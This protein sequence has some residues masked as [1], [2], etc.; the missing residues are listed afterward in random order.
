MAKRKLELPWSA[1]EHELESVQ[2]Q[3]ARLEREIARESKPPVPRRTVKPVSLVERT[4]LVS[5]PPKAEAAPAARPLHP[6]VDPSSTERPPVIVVPSPAQETWPSGADLADPKTFGVKPPVGDLA[7][8]TAAPEE[9]RRR[10]MQHLG[11]A[12]KVVH[13]SGVIAVVW[14]EWRSFERAVEEKLRAL[15]AAPPLS[16]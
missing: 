11:F 3:I 14:R 13:T 7:Q 9:Y 12:S 15:N 1:L 5:T 4:D 6:P 8:G 16:V 2:A 10:L